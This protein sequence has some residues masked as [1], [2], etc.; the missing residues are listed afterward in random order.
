MSSPLELLG[1]ELS[2]GLDPGLCGSDSS[3]PCGHHIVFLSKTRYSQ[4]PVYKWV[5]RI[6]C[7]ETLQWTY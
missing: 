3:P 5:P 7:G 2:P 4:I 1:G 6:Y